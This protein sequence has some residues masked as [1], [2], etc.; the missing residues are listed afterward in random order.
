[1][2]T[3]SHVTPRAELE[4]ELSRLNSRLAQGR[5]DHQRSRDELRRLE[6]EIRRAENELRTNTNEHG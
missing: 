6:A 5:R 4:R 1:M 3:I 2:N